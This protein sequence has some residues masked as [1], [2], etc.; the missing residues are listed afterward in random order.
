MNIRKRADQIA[1][2]A[3]KENL[4]TGLRRPPGDPETRTADCLEELKELLASNL[5]ASELSAHAA[6]AIYR[7]NYFEEKAVSFDAAISDFLDTVRLVESKAI[8]AKS[9]RAAVAKLHRQHP[10]VGI[11][12]DLGQRVEKTL[13][14][15]AASKKGKEKAN[16]IKDYAIGLFRSGTWKNPSQARHALWPQVRAKAI[17]L[18][19]PLTD[20]Q[21]PE[22]LYQ[23]L[24]AHKS[25]PSAS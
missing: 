9:L 16:Q 23:W 24:L 25:T 3:I 1:L 17:E 7:A 4:K 11:A 10:I 13:S 5:D 21:G 20:T 22:T 2:K 14:A 19:K 6:A 15:S 18:G 8:T 12:V